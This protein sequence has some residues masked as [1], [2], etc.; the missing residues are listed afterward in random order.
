MVNKDLPISDMLMMLIIGSYI[1]IG[2]LHRV[3]QLIIL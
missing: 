2:N 3:I 1:G